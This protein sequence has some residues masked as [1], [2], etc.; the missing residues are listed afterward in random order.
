MKKLEKG[1]KIAIVAPSAQIGEISKINKGLAYL[2]SLDLVPVFGKNLLCVNR[3]MAGTDEQRAADINAAFTDSDIKA[4]FCV[5]AAAGATRI[6]PYIDYEL[7]QK[8]PKPVIGFC[9]NVAL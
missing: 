9:D 6:L 1:S 2:Q 3:Y 7:A 4:I 8:N 5:R